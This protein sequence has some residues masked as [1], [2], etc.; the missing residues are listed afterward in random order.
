GKVALGFRSILGRSDLSV[1]GGGRSIRHTSPV[2]FLSDRR[3]NHRRP[4]SQLAGVDRTACGH[5]AC[6][7]LV[8]CSVPAHRLDGYIVYCLYGGVAGEEVMRWNRPIA[9]FS[10]K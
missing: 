10:A 6:R 1:H 9:T 2:L 3:Q 7:V 5:T 4:E 8:R